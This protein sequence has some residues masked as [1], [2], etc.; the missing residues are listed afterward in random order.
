MLNPKKPSKKLFFFFGISLFTATSSLQAQVNTEDEQLAAQYAK[1]YPDDDVLGKTAYHYY[2][3]DKGKN[4]LGDKVVEIQEESEYEFLAL[5]TIF[6]K[7]RTRYA[8]TA[9]DC[10]V[11]SMGMSS[12]Y[13]IALEEGSNMVRIGSLLFGE[14]NYNK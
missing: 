12:D 7:L 4:A 3:F 11:L 13:K 2:S 10:S 5:K 9:I 6:E 14:R 1:T 8:A